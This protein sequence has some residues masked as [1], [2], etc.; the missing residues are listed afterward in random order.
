M[1]CRQLKCFFLSFRLRLVQKFQIF[2]VFISSKNSKIP[3]FSTKTPFIMFCLFHFPHK[4]HF[5]E[6]NFSKLNYIF[7]HNLSSKNELLDLHI[8]FRNMIL[9]I[10]NFFFLHL[11]LLYPPRLQ[12]KK[13]SF[14]SLYNRIYPNHIKIYSLNI[15]FEAE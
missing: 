11:T 7:S 1:L 5:I 2:Q 8:N 4:S 14:L 9:F 15:L 12:L 3:E 6:I 13:L 10:S